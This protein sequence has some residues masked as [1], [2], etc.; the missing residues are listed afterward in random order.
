MRHPNLI[1]E[2]N[3][4]TVFVEALGYRDP[5]HAPSVTQVC[6]ILEKKSAKERAIGFIDSDKK[7][8]AY[9]DQFKPIASSADVKL[10]QHSNKLQYLV[11]V[12]PAMDKFLFNLC[13]ELGIDLTKYRLPTQY[14]AFQELTKKESIRR[15]NDFRNLLNAICQK[16]PPAIEKIKSWIP[17]YGGV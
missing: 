17:K 13:Q 3:V 5:N 1:P 7:M 9:L 16:N 8:P 14:K 15:N 12:M 6:V 4:D 10:L 11:I 2:C